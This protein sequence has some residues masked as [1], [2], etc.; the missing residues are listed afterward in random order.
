MAFWR[1]PN[2]KITARTLTSE[3]EILDAWAQHRAERASARQ[4]ATGA[5]GLD[6]ARQQQHDQDD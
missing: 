1:R 5:R 2:G 6:P 4:A 3:Q